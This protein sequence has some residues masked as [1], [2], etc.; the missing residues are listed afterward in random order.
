MKIG[1]QARSGPVSPRGRDPSSWGD[2]LCTVF[3]WEIFS[4]REDCH[5]PRAES[6]GIIIKKQ[7]YGK[8]MGLQK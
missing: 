2:V 8:K 6:L 7:E 4:L 3:L 5:S 1:N